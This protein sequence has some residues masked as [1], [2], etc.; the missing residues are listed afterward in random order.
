MTEEAGTTSRVDE[1]LAASVQAE[2]RGD[3]ASA[4]RTAK[5][6]SDLAPDNWRASMM[7]GL[8]LVKK[9]DALAGVEACNAA[10]QKALNDNDGHYAPMLALGIA[11]AKAGRL[12]LGKKSM[13]MALEQATPG[14]EKADVL[15]NLGTAQDEAGEH[16]EAEASFRQAAIE[17]P[18]AIEPRAKL[19]MLLVKQRQVDKAVAAGGDVASI[20]QRRPTTPIEKVMVGDVL[21][22]LGTI[23]EDAQKLDELRAK[24]AA[25]R[26]RPPGPGKRLRQRVLLWTYRSSLGQRFAF[27]RPFL[28]G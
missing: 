9:G 2:A 18:D 17:N 7:L 22:L 6:A 13:Q 4:V 14:A 23:K 11:Y 5:E 27:I 19:F 8:A 10:C 24:Q 15:T 26:A 1:L 28:Q 25:A 20:V 21:R 12:D 16:T 3:F